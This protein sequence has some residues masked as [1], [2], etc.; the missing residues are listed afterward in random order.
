[1]KIVVLDGYTLNPG[2]LNWKA[3]EQFGDVK[4]YDRTEF[5]S[6][7]IVKNIAD[8]EAIFTN[9]TPLPKDVLNRVPNVKYIGVLATG[10]NIIDID[11]AK[12]MGMVVANVPGYSTKSVAQFVMALLLEMCHH[13][14]DH[15]QAVKNEQWTKSLDFCFWNTPL[16]E[17]DG[18]TMGIIG[19]GKIGQAT[20]KIAQ[21]FG[22]K[23]VYYSRT[24]KP[25]LE[26]ET[27][28]FV[29]LDDLLKI[30]DIIS[31][32]CPLTEKTEGIINKKSIAKMKDGA[33]LVNT[34]RGGLVVENDLKAALNSGKLAGAAVDV[35]SKEPI[36]ADNPLLQA[37]NCIIT[38]HIAWAPKESRQRMMYT[39]V[40]NLKA[41]LDGCPVNVVN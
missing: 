30:S 39:T 7:A 20:A 35:V 2:D 34:S 6:E 27:C 40:E 18:K 1:M 26:S 25:E 5:D 22:L 38:P 9:K 28:K 4:V 8:A 10:Y 14:G 24:K 31:L 12:K 13:V 36:Q 16:I 3:I 32:H 37:K 19:F 23:I 41:Y 29:S 15:S 17:L 21:A 33:M 11:A